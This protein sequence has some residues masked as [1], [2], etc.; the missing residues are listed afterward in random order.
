MGLK[1]IVAAIEVVYDGDDV[2]S[3]E[4]LKADTERGI[5]LGLVGY[6][7]ALARMAVFSV[8][9]DPDPEPSV[10]ESGTVVRA[11][12]AGEVKR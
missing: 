9:R 12:R 1:R 10:D 7:G 5:S 4:A 3:L 6:Q 2:R 11:P 8:A